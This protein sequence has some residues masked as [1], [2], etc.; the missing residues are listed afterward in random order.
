MTTNTDQGGTQ[1]GFQVY[2]QDLVLMVGLAA[3]L[4]IFLYAT[5]TAPGPL[6]LPG[7]FVYLLVAAVIIAPFVPWFE[8]LVRRYRRAA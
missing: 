6:T 5:L 4:G 2:W 7:L 8:A 1:A 3:I